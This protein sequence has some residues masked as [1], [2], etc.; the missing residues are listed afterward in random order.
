MELLKIK[1][2]KI[3]LKKKEINLNNCCTNEEILKSGDYKIIF[4]NLNKIT[5]SRVIG[6]GMPLFYCLKDKNQ[7]IICSD[8]SSFSKN[9]LSE[10][11]KEVISE[12]ITRGYV[13]PPQTL[14]KNIFRIPLF[15]DLI[16]SFSK[17]E[18]KI[19]FLNN[20]NIVFKK[21]KNS[22]IENLL[23]KEISL[24][25]EEHA[26]LFSGG[27]DSTILAKLSKIKKPQLFST[28]FEFS[29][30]DLLEKKYALSA[31]NLIKLKTKYNS[32]NFKRLLL[33][34]PEMIYLIGE[35]LNHLQTL[36]VYSTIKEN[37]QEMSR[38]IIN[39]QGADGVFGTE[40]QYNYLHKKQNLSLLNFPI[41]KYSFLKK[42]YLNNC[43]KNL[44]KFLKSINHFS[45]LDK[46][47]I[48]DILCDVDITMNSW[49]LC[50]KKNNRQMIYPF[51]KENII[52]NV[53]NTPW[54]E[55]LLEKKYYLRKFARKLNIPEEIISR[56][57]GNFGPISS[58]WNEDLISLV[59]LGRNLFNMKK[60]NHFIKYE[61]NRYNL[62]NIINYIIWRKIY[63][64]G[65]PI[66]DV[67]KKIKLIINHENKRH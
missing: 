43:G 15:K 66:Q 49:S 11:N 19:K 16:I 2:N 1:N 51:F 48:I 57:K 40:S 18:L 52:R 17:Q 26:I 61:E 56:K 13:L 34:L 38:F 59:K 3:F 32:F 55:R 27:L 28:G 44:K 5:V 37:K 10:E 9:L 45:N 33:D 25:R 54:Q 53:V 30:K 36:L 14:F 20:L 50:A 41:K 21:E 58:S 47:F 62:W 63:I 4:N 64:Q 22:N 7:I 39:G 29:E 6:N 8:I 46:D 60:L 35:P 31:A 12:F 65:E 23:K 67:K 24:P 42:E